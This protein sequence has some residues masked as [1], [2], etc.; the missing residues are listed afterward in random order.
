MYKVVPFQARISNTGSGQDLATGLQQIIDQEATGG[1][2]FV[3]IQELTTSIAG[4]SGCF[5]FG[6]TPGTTAYMSVVIFQKQ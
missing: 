3:Q 6:A 2:S 4:S 1:W 5:G